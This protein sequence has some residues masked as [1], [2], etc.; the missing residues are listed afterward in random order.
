[1]STTIYLLFSSGGGHRLNQF[2]LT[3]LLYL[4]VLPSK[5]PGGGGSLPAIGWKASWSGS[6]AAGGTTGIAPTK[7]YHRHR[8]FSLKT[9]VKN[10]VKI[11]NT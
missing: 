8:N 9:G 6:A 5:L 11:V 7:L 1:M 4:S 10:R 2:M 3:V